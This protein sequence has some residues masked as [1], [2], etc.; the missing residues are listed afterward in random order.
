MQEKVS[1]KLYRE[2]RDKIGGQESVYENSEAS[3]I[4]FRCRSNTLNLADRKRF[5]NQPTTCVMCEWEYENLA[6]FLL[7]CPAYREERRENLVLQQPYKEN[8]DN[9]IG[10]LLFNGQYIEKNKKTI[11]KFWKIRE[12]KIKS[13]A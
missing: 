13:L 8:E 2:W 9:I 11:I 3:L 6:H 1:L 7:Q 5:Q 4:M 10:K 12:K